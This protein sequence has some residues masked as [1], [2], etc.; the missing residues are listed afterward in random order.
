MHSVIQIY[1]FCVCI[2]HISWLK[3]TVNLWYFTALLVKISLYW[4]FFSN[5]SD[6]PAVLLFYANYTNYASSTSSI[7]SCI[8]I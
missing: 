4:I 3:L 2:T 1:T 7:H 5:Q 8:Y 6:M